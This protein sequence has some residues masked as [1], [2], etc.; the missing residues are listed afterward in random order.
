MVW[1]RRRSRSPLRRRNSIEFVNLSRRGKRP[2]SRDSSSTLSVYLLTTSPVG[3]PCSHRRFETLVVRSLVMRR[4]GQTKCSGTRSAAHA[5]WP[6]AGSYARCGRTDR[7][8]PQRSPS[9]R[10]PGPS[11]ANECTGDRTCVRP[12][13][14]GP[15]ARTPGAASS[16]GPAADNDCRPPR[17]SRCH[18]HRE[19]SCGQRDIRHRGCPCSDLWATSW[20]A[21][22]HSRPRRSSP[23]RSRDSADRDLKRRDLKR[24]D[25]KG[26]GALTEWIQAWAPVYM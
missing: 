5:R 17:P 21:G 25:L 20:P 10:S 23:T 8:G 1:Q 2:A 13:P 18:E 3:A 15:P 14:G 4:H 19:A 9:R 16:I 26:H 24:R 22:C 11:C 6:D 7:P 12:G